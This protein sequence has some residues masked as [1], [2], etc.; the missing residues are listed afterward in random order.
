M[1]AEENID[2]LK[3]LQECDDHHRCNQDPDDV[4][5]MMSKNDNSHKGHGHGD[6]APKT[7]SSIAWMVIMGDGL[8]N[9]TDGLA[10][11]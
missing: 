3:K 9:F 11:G 2:E 6:E 1:I 8:H 4:T 10:I 5:I 7:I